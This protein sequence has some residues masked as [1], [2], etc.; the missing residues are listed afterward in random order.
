MTQKRA[1]DKLIWLASRW[2][3]EFQSAHPRFT[4][5]AQSECW[6]I[7]RYILGPDL[8]LCDYSYPSLQVLML[9]NLV[10]SGAFLL[11]TGLKIM[12]AKVRAGSCMEC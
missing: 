11:L 7:S 4:T 10:A 9:F 2:A 8:L 5:M 3:E 6:T 1:P 12:W